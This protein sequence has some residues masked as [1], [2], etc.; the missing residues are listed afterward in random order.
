MIMPGDGKSS[1]RAH[2]TRNGQN[3]FAFSKKL[4]YLVSLGKVFLQDMIDPIKTEL[5]TLLRGKSV[6]HGDFV[7]SSGARSKYYVDCKLTTFDSRGA[8]LVGEAMF[9][10]IR[11]AARSLNVRVVGVGG[12]TM[13][14]DP[15]A[16]SVGMISFRKDEHNPWKTF[17]VRKTQKGHGQAKLIEGN[18]EEGDLVV[19]IDDVITKGESTLKAIEAVVEAKGKIAFVAVLVDREEGGRQKIEAQGFRVFQLFNKEDLLGLDETSV[20]VKDRVVA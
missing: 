14:A 7:L 8:W 12:L 1:C 16:L 2:I 20:E 5:L 4:N 17:S 3:N 6:F 15:I 11:S 13:G 18:F 9:D 10:L 19:V